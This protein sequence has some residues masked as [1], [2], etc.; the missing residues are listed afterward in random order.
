M[1]TKEIINMFREVYE[2]IKMHKTYTELLEK[3]I[4]L[5]EDRNDRV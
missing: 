3:R 2:L 1:S 4:K 5:L